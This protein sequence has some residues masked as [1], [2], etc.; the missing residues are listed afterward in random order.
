MENKIH[1][2]SE[3]LITEGMRVNNKFLGL[4]GKHSIT[5]VIQDLHTLSIILSRLLSED[6][7]LDEFK[8]ETSETLSELRNWREQGFH[9]IMCSGSEWIPVMK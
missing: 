2:F 3:R 5:E 9:H 6:S 1:R 8:K 4:S 7:G